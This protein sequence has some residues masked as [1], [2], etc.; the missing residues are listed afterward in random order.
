MTIRLIRLIR[1]QI[2]LYHPLNPGNPVVKRKS[3]KVEGWKGET[4]IVQRGDS[5]NSLNSLANKSVSSVE[6]V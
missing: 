3:G 2:N 5:F 1:W 4:S 6:S